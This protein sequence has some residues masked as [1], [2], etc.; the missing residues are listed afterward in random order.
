MFSIVDTDQKH[1]MTKDLSAWQEYC[2]TLT[3]SLQIACQQ[4]QVS[5]GVGALRRKLEAAQ[6]EWLFQYRFERGG[7]YRLGGVVDASG[8]P[9]AD[10]L[11]TWAEAALKAQG[12]DFAALQE[13][14][15]STPRYATRLVGNT[16]YLVARTGEGAADFLQLEV[17]E[18]QESV[19]HRLGAGEPNSLS[20]LIDPLGAPPGIPPGLRIH[21]EPR[22]S[23]RRLTHVGAMLARMSARLPEP[24]P[25]QR[26]LADWQASSAGATAEFNQHWLIAFREYLDR[27]RQTQYR[28]QVIPVAS[29]RLPIFALAAGANGIKLHA[30]LQTFDR[31]IGYPLAWF[32]HLLITKAIPHWVAQTVVEDALN[33]YA[34][35]PQRD[36]E[37]VRN[38]LHRPYVV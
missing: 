8:A 12:G 33:G 34:Y 26:L 21:S 15:A 18:L 31:Q 32:F 36:T 23:F 16:H 4:A 27:Y 1:A 13:D 11:E 9:I 3:P 14:L 17:E 7:W 38:W 2:K 25:I 28:A 6:P 30:A 22:Y 19:S 37:I 10:N 5:G 35:L 20:E 29:G 24:L